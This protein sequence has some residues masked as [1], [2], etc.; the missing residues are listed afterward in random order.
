LL[1]IHNEQE[2]IDVVKKFDFIVDYEAV[3]LFAMDYIEKNF[4]TIKNILRIMVES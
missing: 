4:L 2:A 3:I 1:R